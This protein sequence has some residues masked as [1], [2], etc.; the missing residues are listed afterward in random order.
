MEKTCRLVH[1]TYGRTIEVPAGRSI[2]DPKRGQYFL[3]CSLCKNVGKSAVFSGR[4]RPDGGNTTWAGLTGSIGVFIKRRLSA[5]C[6]ATP[7]IS[8]D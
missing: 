1:I 2:M 7:K 4:V 8:D 6:M 5:I 3:V